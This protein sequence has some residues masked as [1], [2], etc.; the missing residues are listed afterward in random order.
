MTVAQTWTAA[1]LTLALWSYLIG[2][3]PIWRFAEHIYVGL[4]TA[5]T[6][7]YFWHSYIAPTVTEDI[8]SKGRWSLVIPIVL[9]LM[10]YLRYVPNVSWLA[11]WPLGWWVGYGA[12][13][14]LAFQAKPWIGQITANF[15]ELNNM[16]HIIVVITV[17]L[18]L[19]YFFFI[20]RRKEMPVLGKSVK[21]A[22]FL[23]MAALGAAFGSTVLYRY[24]L[25]ME[26]VKFILF[27]W[28]HLGGG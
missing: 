7:G 20:I 1:I 27:D 5:W 28:L 16:T 4:T 11:R 23:I 24:S 14:V 3:N 2:D 25:F 12:G 17:L 10:I 22:E 18:T 8:L 19:T 9:G 6:F 26:R 15:V 21:A 13:Y